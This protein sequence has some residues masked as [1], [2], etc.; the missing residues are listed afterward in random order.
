MS[1]KEYID[2]KQLFELVYPIGSIYLSA[3]AVNPVDLFGIGTWEKIEDAFLLASGAYAPLGS[4]GGNENHTLTIDEMPSHTHGH[5]DIVAWP[6]VDNPEREW[7]VHY[8]I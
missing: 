1:K 4:I 2:K 6:L 5:P 7:G 3:A 8:K